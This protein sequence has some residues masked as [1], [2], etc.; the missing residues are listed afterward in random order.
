MLVCPQCQTLNPQFSQYCSECRT[1]LVVK[2]SVWFAIIAPI[3]AHPLSLSPYLDTEKR[4]R[5]LNGGR[6]NDFG[7]IET[8]VW[9]LAPKQAPYCTDGTGSTIVPS[10]PPVARP[11]L[12]PHVLANSALPQLRDTWATETYTVLLLKD[13]TDLSCTPKAWGN[14]STLQQLYWMY[15]TID[16]WSILTAISCRASLTD[17]HNLHL[18]TDRIICLQRLYPDPPDR[19]ASLRDLGQTWKTLFQ[20][21]Q[22]PLPADV[23]QFVEQVATD[24]FS[25]TEDVRSNIERFIDERE[26]DEE[27]TA[28]DFLEREDDATVT[29]PIPPV[30]HLSHA[31]QTDIGRQRSHNEDTFTIWTQQNWRETPLDRAVSSRGLY[32]LVWADMREARLPALSLRIPSSDNFLRIGVTSY[33]KKTRSENPFDW[34]TKLFTL[35][36]SSNAVRVALVWEQR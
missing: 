30:V 17:L 14:A 35:S 16:L 3:E 21:T 8:R 32:V 33:R 7:E 13:R 31:G 29:E 11:Y 24:T 5:T 22:T 20:T 1:R 2:S 15:Q 34:R 28:W 36:T 26:A 12:H 4:Y 9:D 10:V 19:S 18:D 6:S 27:P 23:A 25:I